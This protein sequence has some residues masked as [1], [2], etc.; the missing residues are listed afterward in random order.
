MYKY[1]K[2]ICTHK[3]FNSLKECRILSN[4]LFNSCDVEDIKNKINDL[5]LEYV[6]PSKKV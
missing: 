6:V 1:M 2:I 5:S 3:T 4:I